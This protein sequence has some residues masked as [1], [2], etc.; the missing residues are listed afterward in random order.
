MENVGKS[1]LGPEDG[2]LHECRFEGKAIEATT[3]FFAGFRVR[4]AENH[5]QGLRFSHGS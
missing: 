2:I 3:P 5:V 4:C 1:E